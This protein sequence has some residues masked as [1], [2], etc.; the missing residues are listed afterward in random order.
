MKTTIDLLVKIASGL[1]HEGYYKEA[2]TV[3]TIMTRL[4]TQDALGQIPFM[5]K[6]EDFQNMY[7]NTAYGLEKKT[8]FPGS[9]YYSNTGAESAIAMPVIPP[10]ANGQQITDTMNKWLQQNYWLVTTNKD[11]VKADL[12]TTMQSQGFMPQQIAAAAAI[13]GN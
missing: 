2:E 5:I 11:K 10:G 4:A 3:E 9:S 12:T 8:Q 13:L 7:N 1:D 6:P